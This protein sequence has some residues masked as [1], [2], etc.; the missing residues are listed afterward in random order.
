MYC[1][2]FMT[3]IHLDFFSFPDFK[4]ARPLAK[5]PTQ[6]ERTGFLKTLLDKDLDEKIG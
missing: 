2:N 4:Q 6:G 5:V 1:Q 3:N